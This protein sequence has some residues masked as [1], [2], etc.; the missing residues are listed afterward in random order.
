[1]STDSHLI[2]GA[3]GADAPACA[4]AREMVVR[5]DQEER[6]G[7]RAVARSL[8]E[9][10]VHCR[11]TGLEPAVVID[12]LCG[13]AR[14]WQT[15][16]ES[17]AALDVLEVAQ[18][19]ASAC[20]LDAALGRA[21]NIR[22]VIL[23]QRGDYDAA[24]R[25]YLE[26]GA[27]GMRGGDM[28]LT[29]MT[30]QN[31]GI[32]ANVR[33]DITRAMSHYREC[34][35]AY[36]RLGMWR[37][38]S[39]AL[40][41]LGMLHTD[42]GEW[43]SAAAA[44]REASILAER[45]GNRAALLVLMGNQAELALAQG[46]IADAEEVCRRA[47]PMAREMGDARAE[48]ELRK[49]M[50]VIARERDDAAAAE[51]EFSLGAAL[52]S[53]RQDVLLQA[54][55]SR[56]HAELLSRLGRYRETVQALNRAHQLFGQLRARRALAD[57]DRR[58]T[59]LEVGFLEVVREWGESIE[60]K[61]A[62][63]QG[64]CMR[65]ADLACALARR[66]GFDERRMFWFRVGA[67]LHDVGKIDIPAEI[68]NKPGR[69]TAEEWALM[70]SHPEAGVE[71]LKG[72]DFPEDVIPIVLSHHEK[73]DGTGYPHGLAREGIPLVARILGLADVYDALTTARSYKPGL[74]H[75]QA[76]A[77]IR[78][79]AGSHFDPSLV[80]LFERVLDERN[81]GESL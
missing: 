16:G 71:L 22:A 53:L 67:L 50:G 55:L 38:V 6:A 61:D 24:D 54:E 15:D 10:A 81:A 75:A 17:D 59:R 68:L 76:I 79:D 58:Q 66:A 72:I 35:A 26:A 14:T 73:W 80:P 64:H 42:L 11:E 2:P 47:L 46:R 18:F 25:L 45:E 74:P 29:A 44:Y 37:E 19:V 34:I 56:E 20:G 57:L 36:Q 27:C 43:D 48:A 39:G 77:I 78:G 28:R 5:A 70:R 4:E 31:R 63:T 23:W 30:A 51:Q 33:G 65:V 32:I 40:N 60:S 49:H 62:Y 13:I 69:L 21:L 8:Y 9:Q 3:V 12:A 1:M 7:R 52:A 41:N